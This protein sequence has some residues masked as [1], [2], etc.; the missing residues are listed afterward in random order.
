MP[1]QLCPNCGSSIDISIY[2]SG[3]QIPCPRCSL[4]IVVVRADVSQMR[5]QRPTT[6]GR[7]KVVGAVATE[8]ES[9]PATPAKP[10]TGPT[11]LYGEGSRDSRDG[12]SHGLE[13]EVATVVR[14]MLN[15]P[16]YELLQVIGRG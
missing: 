6:S 7:V 12:D 4:T 11:R 1:T 3:Q 16:G 14:P 5:Q 15:V 13:G 8:P 10:P 9:A 2:I